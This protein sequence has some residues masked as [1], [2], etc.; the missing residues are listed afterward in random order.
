MA[1]IKL[2]TFQSLTRV[3]GGMLGSCRISSSIDTAF[4]ALTAGVYSALC[5]ALM[6]SF[7]ERRM[8][9]GVVLSSETSPSTTNA[10]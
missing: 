2:I 1:S 8:F 7:A 10:C 9:L 6:A 3:Y 4:E 5:R